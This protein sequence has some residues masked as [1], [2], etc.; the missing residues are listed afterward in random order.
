MTGT[1]LPR[2]DN[3]GGLDGFHVN[4]RTEDDEDFLYLSMFYIYS[5][6]RKTVN[7]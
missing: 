1:V 5:L 7:T 6:S 2:V 3:K 4:K